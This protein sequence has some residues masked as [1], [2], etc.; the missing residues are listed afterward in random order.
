MISIEMMSKDN[1]NEIYS[2]KKENRDCFEKNLSPRPKNYFE[3]K[4]S[5]VSKVADIVENQIVFAIYTKINLN[6]NTENM[7][8]NSM[9]KLVIK[10][11][12]TSYLKYIY[13][14]LIK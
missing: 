4:V 7:P 6:G 14:E 5:D 8:Y 12:N 3:G 9:G 10:T 13:N 2:F 11:G 1:C